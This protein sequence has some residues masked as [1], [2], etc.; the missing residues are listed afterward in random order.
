MSPAF[1]RRTRIDPRPRESENAL[2]RAVAARRGST[3]L[4]LT[5]SNP[6]NAGLP[7]DGA[8]IT[9]AL[10]SPRALVYEPAPLGLPGARAAISAEYAAQGLEVPPGHVAITAS[11]SEAYAILFKT[12]CDPGDEVLV[13]VPSYPLLAWLASFE[14]AVLRTY[15][16]E[17]A[18][19]WHVDLGALRAAVSP[20][21]RAIV[22]VN[23]NNPTG[24][25]LG[26][27]ELEAM[28]ELGLPIISDE[29]FASYS[30]TETTGRVDSALRADRGLVFALS[31]L[32]K[33]VGLPQM[34][35]GWIACGGDARAAAEAIARLETVL[36]AYL[37]VGAPVQHALEALLAA[38]RT[39]RDA[40]RARTRGNLARVQRIAGAPSAITTLDVEG[41]W[42]ATLRVPETRTD[43][44]WAVAL[45]EDDGVYVH[46]GYFFDM[47]R[48]AHLVV[49]LLTP[50]G[51]LEEGMRRIAA[52]VARET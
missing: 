41:G 30:L 4:D 15:P 31:G 10:A 18:G 50:E 16:L 22:V 2:T 9:A 33:L 7:Y 6:T 24:S 34:K 37:S 52:K 44:E 5:V 46:P 29:V 49:S 26:T 40:I 43:E 25:Y 27:D 3:M 21:T 12:L 51:D 11:T 47:A 45:V 1:S 28:L 32:S 23:P 38:G 17:Y 48:G 36:D 39:T 19:R 35:L 42:Y 14:G 8:R 13:P 20:R